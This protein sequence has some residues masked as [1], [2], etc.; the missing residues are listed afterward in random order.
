MLVFV[1]WFDWVDADVG[2]KFNPLRSNQ[3]MPAST[4]CQ[5]SWQNYARWD[6]GVAATAALLTNGNYE[7][8]LSDLQVRAR[9]CCDI[10]LDFVNCCLFIG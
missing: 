6:D 10:M 4:S 8:M 9:L 1:A 2:C 5:G 3:T 7:L